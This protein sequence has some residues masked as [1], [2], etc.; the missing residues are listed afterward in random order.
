MVEFELALLLFGIVA[1]VVTVARKLGLAYPI[2]L[3]IAGLALGFVPQLPRLELEPELVLVVFL[4]PILF[5]AAWQTPFRDFRRNKRPILLLSV[6]LVL[7]TTVV[8]GLV[9]AWAVPTLPLAAALALGAIVAPPDA[10]AATTIFRRLDVPRRIVTILEGESLVNDATALTAYRA[11]VAVAVSGVFVPSDALL[12]FIVVV[13]GGMAVGL[14]VAVVVAWAWSRLFDPPV[15]ILLSLLIPYAAYLPA[16]ELHV[17]GV[18]AVVTAGLYLGRRSARILDSDARVLGGA[19][20]QIL[21]L[22]LNGL[23]F[24]LIGLQLPIVL[25]GLSGRTTAELIGLAALV[26]VTAIV[27]RIVWVYP[28]TYLPRALSASLRAVDPYPAPA[29]VFVV[30]WAGMRGAV[31][32]AAALALP[33]DFPERDLIIFL[34]FAVILATLVGQGLTLPTLLRRLGVS[35]ADDSELAREQAIARSAANDAALRTLERLADDWPDHR[36]L[37]DRI[38]EDLRHRASHQPLDDGAAG[39]GSTGDGTTDEGA[40]ATDQ[41]AERHEH[42]AILGAVIAAQR[43]AI[44]RLRD[45]GDIGDEVLRQLERELDLEELRLQAEA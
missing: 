1:A 42:L 2:L 11:T 4:P 6:G 23:A 30:A 40:P 5:A 27:A 10:I 16:E 14:A 45:V 38:A 39:D 29:N 28:A 31:S 44:I 36:P 22:S 25:D 8:V 12:E 17:S 15:E 20:W 32:L 34:T 33:R 18:I 19:V 41:D 21:T 37:I 9:A 3:V 13:A 43:E 7:F 24:L 26:S 35:A